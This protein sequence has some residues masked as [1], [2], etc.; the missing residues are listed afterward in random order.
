MPSR[1]GTIWSYS[2]CYKIE[3]VT[4]LVHGMDGKQRVDTKEFELPETLFVRDIENRVF[5]EIVLQCLTNIAD[6]SPVDGSFIDNI[7]GRTEKIKGVHAEQDPKT[8]SITIRLEVNVAYGISIPGKAEEIQTRIA[9]E[10]TKITG[11]HVSMVHVIFKA[12]VSSEDTLKQRLH[13]FLQPEQKTAGSM[14]ASDSYS[15]VF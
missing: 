13:T 15:D 4:F 7:L 3:L 8:H 9:E 10:I 14:N 6:I 12:L 11:L 2:W 5:Q 1:D